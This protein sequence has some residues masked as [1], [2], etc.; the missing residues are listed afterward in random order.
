M[1][2]QVFF[3]ER[4]G[5]SGR[6]FVLQ[7]VAATPEE[8]MDRIRD[9]VNYPQMVPKGIMKNATCFLSTKGLPNYFSEKGGRL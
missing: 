9:L 1:Y 7:D 6:G 3:T 4:N 5:Q 8:C 2:G